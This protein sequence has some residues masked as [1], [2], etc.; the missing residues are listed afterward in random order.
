MRC[1]EKPLKRTTEVFARLL[2]HLDLAPTDQVP[3]P[4][5]RGG[6]QV[7]VG[8][9][10]ASP[11][12]KRVALSIVQPDADD[13]V[14][15][16]GGNRSRGCATRACSTARGSCSLR[17]DFQMSRAGLCTATHIRN[18]AREFQTLLLPAD[19]FRERVRIVLE[20]AG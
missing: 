11:H 20:A 4:P 9:V 10:F 7:C 18:L 2:K 6:L 13:P 12:I 1:R 17:S 14:A 5:P 8:G 16:Y 19:H 3:P 15:R